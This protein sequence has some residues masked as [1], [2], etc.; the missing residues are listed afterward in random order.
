MGPPSPVDRLGTDVRRCCHFIK[1]PPPPQVIVSVELKRS[2]QKGKIKS[3]EEM[4]KL[5][6]RLTY[7]RK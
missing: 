3:K 5:R 1:P 4:D 7:K 6:K 2:L